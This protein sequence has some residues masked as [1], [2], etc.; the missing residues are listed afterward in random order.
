MNTERGR[1]RE[2]VENQGREIGSRISNN[3]LKLQQQRV[4]SSATTAAA[5]NTVKTATAT[6]IY[7]VLVGNVFLASAIRYDVTERN[8]QAFLMPR[9][10]EQRS[11]CR[12]PEGKPRFPAHFL[13]ADGCCKLVLGVG[14]V[15]AATGRWTKL[16]HGTR[17][18]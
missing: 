17:P 13:L 7:S 8:E 14:R 1:G 10:S 12:C 9:Q 15:S 11:V 3:N 16:L 6:L 4:A 2:R 5:A 18:V